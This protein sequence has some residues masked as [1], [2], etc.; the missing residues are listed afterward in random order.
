VPEKSAQST[1]ATLLPLSG[2]FRR[3]LDLNSTLSI[4]SCSAVRAQYNPQHKPKVRRTLL[5]NNA[6]LLLFLG[7]VRRSPGIQK[8]AGY[9][10]KG[11]DPHPENCAGVMKMGRRYSQERSK[12]HEKG[13]PCPPRRSSGQ[14]QRHAE[15]AK[16]WF[17]REKSATRASERNESERR[18]SV[19]PYRDSP[20][21]SRAPRSAKHFFRSPS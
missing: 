8:D 16:E 19:D 4:T 10:M 2:P 17:A 1:R 5:H 11:R 7:K 9:T 15:K 6:L 20:G 14:A 21:S 18:G 13:L 3:L 12:E